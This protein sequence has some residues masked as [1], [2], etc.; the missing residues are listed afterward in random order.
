VLAVLDSVPHKQS[1]MIL[2]RS[3]H[4]LHL[5]DDLL[6]REQLSTYHLAHSA[7]ADLCPRLGCIPEPVLRMRRHLGWLVRNRIV[8]FS[9]A[10]RGVEY[11]TRQKKSWFKY[12][13]LNVLSV[14]RFVSQ[15]GQ[16]RVRFLL[17]ITR[18]GASEQTLRIFRICNGITHVIPS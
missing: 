13:L 4:G 11:K 1:P 6:A 12:R 17:V 5:I 15:I 9:A 8:V 18:E 14:P 16:T 10:A 3:E 2:P 7:R